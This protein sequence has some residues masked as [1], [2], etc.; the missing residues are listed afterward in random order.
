EQRADK[1][2]HGDNRDDRQASDRHRA[3]RHRP[4]SRSGQSEPAASATGDYV[5]GEDRVRGRLRAG[6]PEA[7][8]PTPAPATAPATR[9]RQR[10]PA[11]RRLR[12]TDRAEPGRRRGV[13]PS[14]RLV[15]LTRG[16]AI[17]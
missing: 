17:T 14:H 11:A 16:S 7:W 5:A 12:P 2:E 1:A 6:P 9:P 15:N 3:D 10:G 8:L 13:T 4:T